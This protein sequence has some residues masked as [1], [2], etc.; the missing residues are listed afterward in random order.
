MES[1]RGRAAAG[2]ADRFDLDSPFADDGDCAAGPTRDGYS[3]A[4]NG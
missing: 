3:I 2:I 4:I 1:C